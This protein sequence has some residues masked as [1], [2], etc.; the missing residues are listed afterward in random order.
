[1]VCQKSRYTTNKFGIYI[2]KKKN[3]NQHLTCTNKDDYV[4]YGNSFHAKGGR[5]SKKAQL[6]YCLR[7]L[8]S[9]VTTNSEQ[10]IQDLADQGAVD[11]LSNILKSYCPLNAQIDQI[12]VEI[13]ADI[14]FV[15]SNACEKD[16]H[17]KV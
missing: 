14:L 15:L 9:L 2:I 16:L 12:D 4:G 17:R 13:Q 5:G 7:V 11:L 1:M 3:S 6:K 10:A 8:R